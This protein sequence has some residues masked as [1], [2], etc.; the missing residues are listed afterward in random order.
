[1][2]VSMVRLLQ[3]FAEPDVQ[4]ADNE[5]RHDNSDVDQ[6]IHRASSFVFTLAL[7][8]ACRQSVNKKGAQAC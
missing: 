3:S 7:S 1:M 8:T 5:E 6:V 2:I 4:R